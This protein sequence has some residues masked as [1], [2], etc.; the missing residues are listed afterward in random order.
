M[1]LLLSYLRGNPVWY[2]VLFLMSRHAAGAGGEGVAGA[3]LGPVRVVGDP[4]H[5]LILYC[6]VLYCTILYVLYCSPAQGADG[7]TC[8]VPPC[9]SRASDS[10][11]L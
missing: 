3:V 7:Q 10:S 11:A 9:H 1:E 2:D 6:T 5:L 8:S 4:V